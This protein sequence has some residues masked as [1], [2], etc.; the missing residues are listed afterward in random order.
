M[1]EPTAREFGVPPMGQV[2]TSMLREALRRAMQD[3]RRAPLYALFFAGV[4]VAFGWLMLWISLA[5]GQIY[6]MIF[7]VVSFP[8]IGPFAA[9]GLYE[10]SQRLQNDQ[11]LD[12]DKI[13]GV[14]L[15]Q[16]SGQLP[17]LCLVVLM[18]F[19]FWLFMVHNVFALFM[20]YTAMTN[21]TTSYDVFLTQQGMTML[22]A[23]TLVGAG[24]AL[25]L[26]SITVVALPM[27]VDRE[28]D[29]VSA[30]IASVSLVVNNPVPMLLWAV[31][32]AVLT[33]VAM[34]PA[35]LGLFLV[36]P[37]L[38]HATWHLYDLV[39]AAGEQEEGLATA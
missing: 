19:L 16:G 9:V 18:I 30:M 23:G 36:L 11:P 27:L 3:M 25:V 7:A 33:F 32:I 35:F 20:G 28:V 10:V 8:L 39:K 24:F 38:G 1:S 14:I 21:I 5:T 6:W 17:S 2:S 37:L 22:A 31:F 15:K 12:R 4:Y 29:F 34:L 26:Y 13:F